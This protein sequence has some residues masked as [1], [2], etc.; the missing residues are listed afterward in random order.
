MLDDSI[1]GYPSP[2]PIAIASRLHPRLSPLRATSL[3]ELYHGQDMSD[4]TP[5]LAF[6]DP[7]YLHFRQAYPS[8]DIS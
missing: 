6:L 4:L 2:T 1:L 7:L 5:I 8:L 3:N